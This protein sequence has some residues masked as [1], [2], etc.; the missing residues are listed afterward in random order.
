M[1]QLQGDPA[2]MG[3]YGRHIGPP[4]F[5]ALNGTEPGESIPLESMNGQLRTTD[6]GDMAPS[7]QMLKAWQWAC[8]D[9]KTVVAG[10]KTVTTKSLPELNAL[11]AKNGLSPVAIPTGAL[12]V[13][14]C[15]GGG[16]AA[17]T[18]H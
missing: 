13:P 15:G 17:A 4:T 10:W 12:P 14:P 18:A 3:N 1:S 8:T 9:L 11:L 5:A 16:P 2:P 7:V 6:Y